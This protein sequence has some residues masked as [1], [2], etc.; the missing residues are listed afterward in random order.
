MEGSST[1]G[2]PGDRGRISLHMRRLGLPPATTVRA[3]LPIVMAAALIVTACQPGVG[4]PGAK[5]SAS[6]D[7][8]SPSTVQPSASTV[9]T[10]GPL[11]V[12][13]PQGGMDT[14]RTEGRLRI[15]DTCVYL[16]SRGEVTLL[17]WPADRTMW[18][19]ESR[20]IT[21]DNVDG[22]VVTVGDGD[23]VILGGSGGPGE[24]G[25]SGEEFVKRTAWVAPPASSCTLDRW[26]TVAA[27]ASRRIDVGQGDTDGPVVTVPGA[28]NRQ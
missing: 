19:E 20:V 9:D 28:A 26:W 8:A 6:P 25:I 11:A 15:T 1:D 27:L 21:Y 7:E 10:W 16:E 17:S 13:P 4:Q 24:D 22:S 18:S 12:I 3:L 14:L 5:A 2:I 23:H